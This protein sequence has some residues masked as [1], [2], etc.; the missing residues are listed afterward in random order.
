M[1][2]PRLA[3]T[4]RL[5]S[6]VCTPRFAHLRATRGYASKSEGPSAATTGLISL[7]FIV[8]AAGAYYYETRAATFSGHDTKFNIRIAGK[9][10]TYSRKTDAELETILTEH[11]DGQVIGRRGNP[12]FRWDRNW[13]G[14]NEPCEDRSAVDIIPRSAGVTDQAK[15]AQRVEGDRDIGLFS[16]IDG[17]AGDATSKLLAKA[18]HPTITLELAGLQAEASGGKGW[19][20][21]NPFSWFATGK[22]WDPSTVSETIKKA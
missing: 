19:N 2:G 11:E 6:R 16:I 15:H 14:S 3:Q 1:L 20:V 8:A 4:S 18:L 5:T 7:G 9:D 13:V 12:V 22:S 21:L 17:H 10:R